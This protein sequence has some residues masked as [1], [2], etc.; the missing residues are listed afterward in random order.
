MIACGAITADLTRFGLPA[1][2]EVFPLPPWLHNHPQRIA[3][4][5]RERH[6]RIAADFDRVLLGYAD[7]GTYGEL[8]ELAAELGMTLLPGQHCYDLY[9]GAER[10]T[11][12]LEAEPG[13]YFLTDFLVAA[14]DRA[15]WRELGLD[16][17]PELLADYFGHY[18]KVIWLA[19][20]RTP[21][22]ERAAQ[23]A[24]AR[25]GLPLE[26]VALAAEPPGAG[27]PGG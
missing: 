6:E 14:F 2:A 24:A 1:T 20:R 13:T 17:H 5:V 21:D 15:V 10:V 12:W 22:L 8:A 9:A 18:R 3:A 7:C 26:V 4:A 16:R 23:R 27:Q 25:L 19:G 11:A